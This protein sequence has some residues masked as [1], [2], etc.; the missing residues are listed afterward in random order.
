MNSSSPNAR[1]TPVI[2]LT[3]HGRGKA[4]RVVCNSTPYVDPCI[5]FVAN[6]SF[7]N[8]FTAVDPCAAFV[9]NN[10]FTNTFGLDICIAFKANNSLTNSLT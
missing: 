1:P 3:K 6:N 7:T 10:S 4:R 5:A 8:D 2:L 9:A